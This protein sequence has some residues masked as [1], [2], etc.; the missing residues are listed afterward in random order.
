MNNNN[1]TN[2]SEE[3][4]RET[5]SARSKLQCNNSIILR[6]Y[7]L[8]RLLNNDFGYSF[9]LKKEQ[10]KSTKGLSYYPI[11]RIYD[12]KNNMLFNSDTIE[13]KGYEKT[14]YC[15]ALTLSLMQQELTKKGFMFEGFGTNTVRKAK[16]QY[17]GITI[18]KIKTFIVTYKNGTIKRFD[19]KEME[20]TMGVDYL[21]KIK[22]TFV[23]KVDKV[24]VNSNLLFEDIRK[25][26]EQKENKKLRIET[27]IEINGFMVEEQYT[28]TTV[29]EGSDSTETEEEL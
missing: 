2:R 4:T 28:Y 12:E 26:I 16:G 27:L 23:P 14:K 3:K 9:V 1:I 17:E 6:G 15:R 11:E 24:I 10:R 20:S 19:M 25:E 13:L 21:N 29:K 8:M 5:D 22:H 7:V 18:R